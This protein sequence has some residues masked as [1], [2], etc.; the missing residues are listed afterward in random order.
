MKKNNGVMRFDKSNI[1][2]T[3]SGIDKKMLHMVWLIKKY[4][5]PYYEYLSD[6]EKQK[7]DEEV[8]SVEETYYENDTVDLT[9]LVHKAEKQIYEKVKDKIS[10]TAL[11]MRDVFREHVD[12]MSFDETVYN[13]FLTE[14][15]QLGIYDLERD[16]INT[17]VALWIE[18]HSDNEKKETAEIYARYLCNCMLYERGIPDRGRHYWYA[19]ECFI[20]DIEWEAQY[21]LS[22][23]TVFWS[24]LCVTAGSYDDVYPTAERKEYVDKTVKCINKALE[25]R[26]ELYKIRDND[27]YFQSEAY[28]IDLNNIGY[29]LLHID[30]NK[31]VKGEFGNCEKLI[32]E[33]YDEIVPLIKNISSPRLE[34]L[35][36]SNLGAVAGKYG[37]HIE[38]VRYDLKALDIKRN[39]I[40]NEKYS[41]TDSMLTTVKSHINIANN[42]LMALFEI[43]F[44]YKIKGKDF[45]PIEKVDEYISLIGTHAVEAVRLRKK[46][47]EERLQILG[48]NYSEGYP[49]SSYCGLSLK[50]VIKR[51]LLYLD[52]VKTDCENQIRVETSQGKIDLLKEHV[53]SINRNVAYIEGIDVHLDGIFSEYK[54]A[55][56]NKTISKAIKGVVTEYR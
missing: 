15:S 39:A 16:E 3:L 40:I 17:D 9:S 2:K 12:S 27:Q 56:V 11:I 37:N 45:V 23:T 6:L 44:I 41:D 55:S 26:R 47:N 4:E 14:L 34:A 48:N 30:G 35:I 10:K 43:Q 5:M 51:L 42:S 52:E 46:I 54:K 49:T 32:R 50:R 38:A 20:N 28:A 8:A 33:I 25:V 18:R 36:I 1:E 29:T 31:F 21:N 7:I 19:A 53:K 22:N 24:L 13:R